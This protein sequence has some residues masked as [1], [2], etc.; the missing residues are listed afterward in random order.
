[1]HFRIEDL[2]SDRFEDVLAIMKDKHLLDEPMY[3]SKGVRDE[4]DSLSEMVEN[5]S[6]MLHQYISLVCY[7]EGSE[8]II[9]LNILGVIYEQEFDA[10]K[11]VRKIEKE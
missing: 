3:S 2:Q 10:P 5:W 6:N 4:P 9:A 1:M 7:K 11:D 8:E